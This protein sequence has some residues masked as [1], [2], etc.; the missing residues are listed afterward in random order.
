MKA[1]KRLR[2]HCQNSTVGSN[3][4]KATNVRVVAQNEKPNNSVGG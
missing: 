1:K 3:N 2:A 4:V